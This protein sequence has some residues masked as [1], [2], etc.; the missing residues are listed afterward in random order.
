M[1][2]PASCCVAAFM[3][4]RSAAVVWPCRRFVSLSSTRARRWTQS[5]CSRVLGHTSLTRS[6][7]R[8]RHRRSPAPELVC[9]T[10]SGGEAHGGRSRASARDHGGGPARACAT[11]GPQSRPRA[12]RRKQSPGPSSGDGADAGYDAPA[13]GSSD[14]DSRAGGSVDRPDPHAPASESGSPTSTPCGDLRPCHGPPPSSGGLL[15]TPVGR[16]PLDLRASTSH[17]HACSSGVAVVLV[18]WR[19]HLQPARGSPR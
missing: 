13:P 17:S 9:P 7:R 3:T 11:R 18:R 19:E 10:A 15:P 6:R 16:T 14:E 1:P 4:S 8:S 12:P 5:R 2:C